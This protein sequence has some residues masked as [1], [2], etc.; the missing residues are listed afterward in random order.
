M[1]K[2]LG[3]FFSFFSII[4]FSQERV[5]D[6]V[7]IFDKHINQANKSQKII[8]ISFE[9]FTKNTTNLSD[10][11]RFQTPVYIKENGRGMLSSPSFRGTTAQQTAFV[12]NGI[13]VNSM[14]LAQGDINNLNLLGYDHLAIKSG[15][16]SVLYGSGA[17]G[18]TIHLNNTL[19]FNEGLKN[20]LF[21]EYGAYETYNT[22]IKSS[23]SNEKF[24]AKM[25][26]N[27]TQ[28]E[29]DYQVDSEK[30]INRNGQYRNFTFNLGSGYKINANNKI[31]WQSHSYNGIQHFPIFFESTTKTKYETQNFRS[32]INWEYAKNKLENEL[33]LAYLEENFQ[34]YPDID[35]TTNTGS[36]GKSYIVKNDLGY[37]INSKFAL[38]TIAEYQH[39]QGKGFLNGIKSPKRNI[40]STAILLRSNISK[41]WFVDLGI[42]KDFVE[43]IQSPLLFSIG[44]KIDF[45]KYYSIKLNASKN[46]RFPSFNDLYWEPGGNLDLKSETS[47]QAELGHY[48]KFNENF[49]I[50]ITPYY[51]YIENMIQWL[52][53]T[54]GYWSPV[55]V[56]K[57]QNYGLE[58]SAS[59]SVK[60]LKHTVSFNIGHS[61][62]K[63]KNLE[64]G[65]AMMYVPLHKANGMVKYQ[66]AALELYAQGLL[67][68]LT[69]TTTDEN[70]NKALKPYFVM[71]SGVNFNLNKLGKIG[72]RVNN[73]TG[74]IYKTTAYYP[75]PLTNFNINYMINF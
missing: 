26:V 54:S 8:K 62:T 30:Y 17:I 39:N 29:N 58:S 72:F 3:Y 45:N 63:S 71:N 33:K 47:Y 56:Y 75:M 31:I 59:F 37:R 53:T 7:I 23:F 43:D 73:I 28:S 65:N 20:E 15:G 49:R 24:T 10:V 68:G 12:W 5:I 51:N 18:G 11:L 70:K 6:T 44:S 66:Y 40:F 16:G 2:Y 13:N 50:D 22:F 48:I 52:P 21:A 25:S 4:T 35:Q 61:Y 36:T 14:F 32:L 42:K 69:Y 34:Y 55:N 1:N 67:N 38:N 57:V 9:D 74:A 46:F 60:Y 27:Y 19:R 64:T 41:N